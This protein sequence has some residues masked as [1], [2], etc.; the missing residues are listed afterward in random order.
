V[1]A[2]AGYPLVTDLDVPE[3]GFDEQGHLNNVAVLELFQVLRRRYMGDL[4][5][6]RDSGLIPVDAVVGV[7]EVI[8]RYEAELLPGEA[9]RGG[10]RIVGRSERAYLFDEV[11]VVDD[12]VI[13]RCKVLE[14]VVDRPAARAMPIP[15][16]LWSAI[17]ATEGR[18]MAPG[19]LPFPRSD[20]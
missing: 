12:R 8:C 2:L 14:C 19:T 4:I 18:R 9:V 15:E 6:R 3:S 1:D 10:C 11:L 20:W 7:R 17:E 5:G 16:T 13:A